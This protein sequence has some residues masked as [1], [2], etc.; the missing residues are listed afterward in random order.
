MSNCCDFIIKNECPPI[1][2]T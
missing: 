1:Q 2:L